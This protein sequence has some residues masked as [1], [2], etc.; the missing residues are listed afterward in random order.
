VAGAADQPGAQRPRR[1]VQAGRHLLPVRAAALCSSH[2]VPSCFGLH[3]HP[4]LPPSPPLLS[5]RHYTPPHPP[6]QSPRLG[7]EARSL[8]YYQDAHRVWP[9]NLDVISWLG[10]YHV[11]TGGRGWGLA[12]LVGFGLGVAGDRRQLVPLTKAD[13][14]HFAP[15]QRRRLPPPPP[16][17]GV[18]EGHPLL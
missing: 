1:A 10:A 6:P 11:R 13:Q 2:F 4:R 8:A 7:E 15:P 16:Q 3:L 12:G 5:T 9:V 17:R 14:S 18:R